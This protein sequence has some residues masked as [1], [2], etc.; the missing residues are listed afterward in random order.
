MKLIDL[1]PIR[2]EGSKLDKAKAY[3]EGITSFGIGWLNE[4]QIQEAA[5]QQIEPILNNQYTLLRNVALPGKKEIPFILVGET[6]I[7]VFNIFSKKG[8]FKAKESSWGELEKNTN[9]YLV[10]QDNPITGATAMTR[11]LEKY[12]ET[13]EWQHPE[14]QTAILC[15]DAGTHV[16]SQQPT[17]RVIMRDAIS[18]LALSIKEKSAVISPEDIVRTVELIR[19]RRLAHKKENLEE[20]FP[21][22]AA[23]AYTPSDFLS[24]RAEK[25]S[26]LPKFLQ[27]FDRKQ[28]ILLAALIGFEIL[29]VVIFFII[30]VIP[31]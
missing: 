3:F 9:K 29:A 28:L 25:P 22:E 14:I 15:P 24:T 31:F 18:R 19:E 1:S 12:L 10:K 8:I 17:V 16:D 5:I 13:H 6:G 20:L 30:L 2:I 23:D 21:V 7:H 11:A 26:R 4:M 27:K